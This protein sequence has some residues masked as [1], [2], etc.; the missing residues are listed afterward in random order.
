MQDDSS[1]H[2]GIRLPDKTGRGI[3]YRFLQPGDDLNA[4]TSMLHEAYAPLAAQGMRFVASHQDSATTRKRID[5]GETIV[6][7]DGGSGGAS[8][9]GIITLNE[10][11]KTAGSPFYDR[12][13]V[14][15]FSQFAVRPSY[16][17]LGIGSTL[18][19]LVEERARARGVAE[20]ALDT[21]ERAVRLIDL[22]QS[23]GYRFVEHVQWSATNYRSVILA[24]RLE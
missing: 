22:Y 13:D 24:K 11:A 4:V 15:G 8:I 7:V 5:R 1:L 12:P 6:A 9:V 21:S 3:L 14:A 23:K 19:R 2:A 10:A 17:G 20:L 16:Q 18:L